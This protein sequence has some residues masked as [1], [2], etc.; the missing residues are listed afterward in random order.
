MSSLSALAAGSRTDLLPPPAPP[1]AQ[2]RYTVEYGDTLSSVA[3]RHGLTLAA[4]HAANPQVLNPD[5]VYPGD[6]L[7]LPTAAVGMP[8]AA[9]AAGMSISDA[10]IDLIKGFEGLRL[11]SYQDSAGVWTIGYGHTGP[12]VGPGQTITQ[13]QAEALLRQDVGW[14]ENAVRN[15]VQVPLGQGQFDA[16]VS[17]TFNVGAGAF[18]GSTLLQKLNAGDYAGAQNEFGR[19]I[20]A[21][22]QVLPGLV[23]RRA[24]EAELFGNQAPGDV[25]TPP[26]GGSTYTVRPGDTLSGIAAAHGVTLQA[27][28]AANPEI[29][30]PDLI[31]VGQVIRI[32]A[33]GA[34]AGAAPAAEAP[35]DGSAPDRAG[36]GGLSERYETSGRGPGT[37]SSGNG[38]PGGVSY[39]TY[40]LAGN[41]GRPQEFLANEGS[42]WAA[43]FGGAAPGS[44]SF[45]GTW[46]AIAAR[47]PEA[48]GQA[49]HD[50]IK[51]THYDVQV[52]RVQARTGIDVSG[53]SAAV[54][55]VVWSTAV[56]HGPASDIVAGAMGKVAAQGLTPADG[57]AYDRA[58]IHAVYDERGRIDANGVPVHFSSSSADVQRAVLER[59]AAERRDALAMLDAR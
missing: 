57:A 51:R 44:A 45:T 43:E 9:S 53:R 58:L 38:D 24:A 4:L 22:G 48:F 52:A 8:G 18:G 32:P 56:Q 17:F 10:G 47:E 29:A 30:N 7:S 21:G 16:L 31:Q 34:S 26:P 15:N 1:A 2:G 54:Q 5:V 11:T 41:L 12:E 28:L 59:F 35:R 14:A 33:P 42:R 6:V 20:H 19:W 50:F 55:D 27:L 39:G 36:L 37:V 25:G 49:Q 23:N 3:A 13:A 46:K 40:Q